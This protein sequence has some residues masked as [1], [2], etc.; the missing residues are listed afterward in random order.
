MLFFQAVC[1]ITIFYRFFFI[2]IQTFLSAIAWTTQLAKR[3]FPQNVGF[4]AP[5]L[6][7]LKEN[8]PFTK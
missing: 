8:Y 5:M 4:K 6:S 2:F 1:K 3:T 7:T